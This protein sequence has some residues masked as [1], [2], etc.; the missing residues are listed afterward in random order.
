MSLIIPQFNT[1]IRKKIPKW[2]KDQK[3]IINA[4]KQFNNVVKSITK[5]ASVPYKITVSHIC[6]NCNKVWLSDKLVKKANTDAYICPNCGCKL[7]PYKE[8]VKKSFVN[9]I[10]SI[11]EE[12]R[13]D[14]LDKTASAN[15]TYNTF[16]DRRI[17]YEGAMK[18]ARY[19]SKQGMTGCIANYLRSEHVK[20]AGNDISTFNKI[21]YALE[22]VYGRKQKGRA[23]ASIK[24]DPAGN[25]EFP[26]VFKVASG[27]EYPF[28][29]KNIR[30]LEKEPSLFNKLPNIRKTDTYIYRK[31][32]PSRFRVAGL[33]R[34][35]GDVKKYLKSNKV[36]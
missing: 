14:L 3:S 7:I 9:N 1:N 11:N 8:T 27:M 5:Q 25:F 28:N 26:K 23:I 4:A 29:E 12:K 22:W 18:L 17:V 32:D 19:A 36:I 2:L 34:K 10:H 33:K 30:S 6:S 31:P 13:V 24:I 15:G 21:D 35:V 16:I 20:E